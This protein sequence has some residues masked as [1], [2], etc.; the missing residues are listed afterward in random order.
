MTL[1][2]RRRAFHLLYTKTCATYQVTNDHGLSCLRKLNTSIVQTR[3][4]NFR[5]TQKRLHNQNWPT[6]TQ[7]QHPQPLELINKRLRCVSY[8]DAY[9]YPL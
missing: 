5:T 8:S 1:V 4:V 7:R 2:Y 6:L 9:S 3:L